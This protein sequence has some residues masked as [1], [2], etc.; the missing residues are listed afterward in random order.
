MLLNGSIV[1]W[2]E[3][4]AHNGFDLKEEFAD[5]QGVKQS[6]DIIFSNTRVNS[7]M[8]RAHRS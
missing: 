5:R 2:L 7:S 4:A 3:P 1:Q 6:K 8:V